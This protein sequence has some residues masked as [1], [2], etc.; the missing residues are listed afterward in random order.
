MK[1]RPKPCPIT[2]QYIKDKRD[3]KWWKDSRWIQRFWD[4]SHGRPRIPPYGV[5]TDRWDYS[6]KSWLTSKNMKS[7]R[8]SKREEN[9]R[10]RARDKQALYNE[11]NVTNEYIVT[12]MSP[13]DSAQHEVDYRA[14]YPL[15]E[16]ELRT[17]MT[18]LNAG[19][20]NKM[21]ELCLIS[22]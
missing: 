12:S 4:E 8:A 15:R 20:V 16:A 1:T 2:A 13:M 5:P 6:L 19:T 17:L 7:R 22:K 9:K 3:Y 14:S 10:R 11:V 21:E 18:M